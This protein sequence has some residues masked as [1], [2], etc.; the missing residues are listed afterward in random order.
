MFKV[1][2]AGLF[3]ISIRET[4]LSYLYLKYIN[5][6][7]SF[8]LNRKTQWLPLFNN[9]RLEF[10]KF[11]F[12]SFLNIF[13]IN[14]ENFWNCCSLKFTL[15]FYETFSYWKLYMYF[16]LLFLVTHN[17]ILFFYVIF[18]IFIKYLCNKFVLY[19]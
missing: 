4:I 19:Y 17:F 8:L 3:S 11:K 13:K 10:R 16:F 7:I 2:S 9:L 6:R 14:F 12:L 18:L 1:Q 15:L 5:L